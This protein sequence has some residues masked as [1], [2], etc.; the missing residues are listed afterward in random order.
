MI[1]DITTTILAGPTR[2]SLT[3]I[4]L[5]SQHIMSSWERARYIPWTKI[6]RNP[7]IP[8]DEAKER[9]F[10]EL[11]RETIEDELRQQDRQGLDNDAQDKKIK[12]PYSNIEMLR[13]AAFG[14][15]IGSITGAVF[16]STTCILR[17]G[18]HVKVYFA[19]SACNANHPFQ[20]R[21]VLWTE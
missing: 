16:V 8:L 17:Q 12:V 15:C 18:T 9:I 4:L 20:I 2:H 11:Q 10:R 14:G 19:L 6:P 5:H 7:E 3:V 1:S 13:Q 21:R